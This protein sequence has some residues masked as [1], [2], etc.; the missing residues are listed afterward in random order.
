MLTLHVFRISCYLSLKETLRHQRALQPLKVGTDKHTI[1]EPYTQA[2]R[3]EEGHW[4]EMRWKSVPAGPDGNRRGGVPRQSTDAVYE[5]STAKAIMA[6]ITIA[7]Q[8]LTFKTM[9]LIQMRL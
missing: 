4:R 1:N 3:A 6:S 8:R 2:A 7:L 9:H 5:D